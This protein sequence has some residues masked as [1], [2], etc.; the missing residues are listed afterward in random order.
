LTQVV[1]AIPVEDL[2]KIFPFVTNPRGLP[3]S[4]NRIDGNIVVVLS[5]REFLSFTA[6]RP[7]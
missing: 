6:R 3:E 2:E 1:G 5:E 4:L 7:V